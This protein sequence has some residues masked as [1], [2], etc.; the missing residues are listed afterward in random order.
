[1]LNL[2]INDVPVE[3]VIKY[4]NATISYYDV[5]IVGYG[6]IEVIGS[7]EFSVMLGIIEAEIVTAMSNIDSGW[8]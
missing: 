5:N 7:R 2:I 4:K 1:M 8:L 6:S 3:V